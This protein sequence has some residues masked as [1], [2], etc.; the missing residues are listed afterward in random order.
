MCGLMKYT[1]IYERGPTSWQ[2]DILVN[3]AGIYDFG[4]LMR[5]QPE[6]IAV[7]AFFLASDDSSYITG[8]DLPVRT[9][10]KLP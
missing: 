6:E 4:P 1:V 8:V 10:L 9:D 2:L 3:N 5:L 7:A